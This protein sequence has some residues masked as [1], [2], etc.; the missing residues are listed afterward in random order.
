MKT[1]R[2]KV[3]LYLSYI[4]LI[5]AAASGCSSDASASQVSERKVDDEVLNIGN[6]DY[7]VSLNKKEIE[8]IEK[9]KAI[10]NGYVVG[11]FDDDHNSTFVVFVGKNATNRGVFDTHYTVTVDM[12]KQIVV[13]HDQFEHGKN[14]YMQYPL[15]DPVAIYDGTEHDLDKRAQYAL[16][17][18]G[19]IYSEYEVY[20][21]LETTEDDH[22][23]MR[24]GI[25]SSGE[26][27]MFH[28]VYYVDVDL[29]TYIAYVSK[30]EDVIS[31][32]DKKEEIMLGKPDFE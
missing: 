19:E 26:P 3:F 23:N 15:D 14:V 28:T 17:R 10:Y 27:S 24:V 21:N 30:A 31:G 22:Y 25:S 18:I 5:S 9:L 8:T 7:S 1:I 20:G 16:D 12:E 13:E 4:A 32:V 6:G 2:S 29:K 11:T